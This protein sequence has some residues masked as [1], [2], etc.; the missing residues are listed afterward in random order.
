MEYN[1]NNLILAKVYVYN[2]ISTLDNVKMHYYDRSVL[3]YSY[4]KQDRMYNLYIF[5]TCRE[6]KVNQPIDQFYHY[7][8]YYYFV[9]HVNL[10]L[11][12]FINNKVQIKQMNT[13]S[14]YRNISVFNNYILYEY[15]VNE[16]CIFKIY[17][18]T[19]LI[20]T[21]Q[22]DMS[23][24]CIKNFKLLNYNNL[25]HINLVYLYEE[26]TVPNIIQDNFA[27]TNSYLEI[28]YDEKYLLFSHIISKNYKIL[29]V[30]SLKSKLLIGIIKFNYNIAELYHSSTIMWKWNYYFQLAF[31]PGSSI[32]ILSIHDLKEMR[33]IKLAKFRNTLVNC[34]LQYNPKLNLIFCYS[35]SSI[36]IYTH[37]GFL[38]TN[39]RLSLHNIIYSQVSN[40]YVA[41]M[42]EQNQQYKIKCYSIFA[43]CDRS[44]WSFTQ[45]KTLF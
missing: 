24:I 14:F 4:G 38:L 30:F 11:L 31:L 3:V 8:G 43:M 19:K 45:D 25:Y 41:Q 39:I 34:M 35:E 10:H 33:I 17:K 32:G 18:N 7:N 29:Y 6:Y 44:N 22:V 26:Y 36:N 23:A 37:M 16:Y 2:F 12:T 27:T 9:T 5:K 13:D 40:K 1:L 21:F 20:S 28:D 42:I 15:H